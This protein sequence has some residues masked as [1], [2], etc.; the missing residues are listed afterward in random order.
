MGN[1]S[2]IFVKFMESVS[3]EIIVKMWYYFSNGKVCISECSYH[4][5]QI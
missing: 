1:A 3:V 2:A 5:D 4:E